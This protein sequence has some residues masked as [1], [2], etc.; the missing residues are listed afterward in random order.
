MQANPTPR[1]L[2]E[3]EDVRLE[4]LRLENLWLRQR[5]HAMVKASPR[6]RASHRSRPVV[7]CNCELCAGR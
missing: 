4:Q 3:Y 5:M 7:P 2:S 1:A 6:R